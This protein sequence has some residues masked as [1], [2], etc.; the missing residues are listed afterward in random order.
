MG[1]AAAVTYVDNLADESAGGGEQQYLAVPGSCLVPE[2]RAPYGLVSSA[3]PHPGLAASPT[4]SLDLWA[5]IG[6]TTKTSIISVC[7]NKL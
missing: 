2:P 4:L 7:F 3:Q 5:I 1:R 6:H